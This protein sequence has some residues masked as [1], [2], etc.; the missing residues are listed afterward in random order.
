MIQYRRAK[1]IEIVCRVCFGHFLFDQKSIDQKSS[2]WR[3]PE[4]TQ[5]QKSAQPKNV[6]FIKPNPFFEIISFI[7]HQFSSLSIFCCFSS[8]FFQRSY[9]ANT[10]LKNSQKVFFVDIFVGLTL[11]R[12]SDNKVL[13]RGCQ[14]WI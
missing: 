4:L 12:C 1:K 14:M 10:I 2:L 7:H 11:K 6:G 3:I 13:F 9:R 8:I 5:I